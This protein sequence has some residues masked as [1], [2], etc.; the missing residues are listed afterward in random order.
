MSYPRHSFPDC[1][2]MSRKT[3]MD[4]KRVL[5]CQAE[6]RAEDEPEWDHEYYVA[7]AHFNEQATWDNHDIPLF[8]LKDMRPCNAEGQSVG[9]V[10]YDTSTYNYTEVSDTLFLC[11]FDSSFICRS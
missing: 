3:D 5:L 9:K 4:G 7:T 8:S 10:L 1:A 2:T 11:S 6:H